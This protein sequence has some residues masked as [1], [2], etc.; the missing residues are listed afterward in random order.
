MCAPNIRPAENAST[1]LQE[2]PRV[3]ET[4][5]DGA[6]FQLRSK[7][8]LTVLNALIREMTH[9]IAMISS[10]PTNATRDGPALT[11]MPESAPKP[12]KV[13]DLAAKTDAKNIANQFHQNQN[14]TNATSL[15][16]NVKCA[17]ERTQLLD[18]K[19][20]EKKLATTV[21]LHQ[22]SSSDATEPTKRTHHA[23]DATKE[24][25]DVETK[26]RYAKTAHHQPN[27]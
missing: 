10:I 21:K 17:T 11:K 15:T 9:I 27:S 5:A 22:L 23:R 12:E 3:A 20:T 16:T 13:M 14:N 2:S 19:K 25:K 26:S 7:M 1:F 8:E 4:G 18:A 6:T 24:T